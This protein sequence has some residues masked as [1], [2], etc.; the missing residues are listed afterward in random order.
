MRLTAL[1]GALLVAGTALAADAPP[2][3]LRDGEVTRAGDVVAFLTHPTDRYAHGVLGDAIEAEG[4][5][6]ERG[7]KRHEFRLTDGSVFEDRRVRLM[8]VDGDAAPEAIIVR[9]YPDKGAAIAVY[10]LGKAKIEPLAETAPV[11]TANR[12]LN[13]VGV[14][15]MGQDGRKFIAAVITPHLAGSLRFYELRGKGLVEVTRI[16]GVTNHINGSRNLDLAVVQDVDGDGA[17]DIVIPTLDRKALAVVMLR[18]GKAQIVERI[19]IRPGRVIELAAQPDKGRFQV[20]TEGGERVMVT[21]ALRQ[22][23]R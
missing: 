4:F 6:V 23:T 3:L 14:V 8:D 15:E 1:A 2:P 20:L 11:G 10:R 17:D 13:P 21:S 7:G 16:D 5:A 19:E 12:W 9:S 18:A 22:K